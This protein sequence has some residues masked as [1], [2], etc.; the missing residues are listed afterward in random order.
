MFSFGRVKI[1]VAPLAAVQLNDED[2]IMLR[3]W[4]CRVMVVVSVYLV[5]I[6]VECDAVGV[7]EIAQVGGQ[8]AHAQLQSPLARRPFC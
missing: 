1:K 8:V 2:L 3:L 7:A 6:V 5:V 4:T